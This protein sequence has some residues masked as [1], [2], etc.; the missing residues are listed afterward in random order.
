MAYVRT[1]HLP[2]RFSATA[3]LLGTF[4]H[5]VVVWKSLATHGACIAHL[6]A[7]LTHAPMRR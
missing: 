4:I 6:G 2:A 7:D 1:G 3:A 5:D